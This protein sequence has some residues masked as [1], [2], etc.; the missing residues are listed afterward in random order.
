MNK[1]TTNWLVLGALAC[2]AQIAHAAPP[3]WSKVA[4]RDIQVFHAGV[5]PIE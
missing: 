3:D 2:A 4:K 1:K 5:T